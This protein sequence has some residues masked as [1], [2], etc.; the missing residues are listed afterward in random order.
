MSSPFL[1]WAALTAVRISTG[2]LRFVTFF[3]VGVSMGTSVI[4][5]SGGD[6][7]RARGCSVRPGPGRGP[8]GAGPRGRGPGSSVDETSTARDRSEEDPERVEDRFRGG[9]SRAGPRGRL[10]RYSPGRASRASARRVPGRVMTMNRH[11]SSTLRHSL[12]VSISR[13][14]SA[15][16]MKKMAR[17]GGAPGPCS[18]SRW[19]R[20]SRRPRS[21]A[22][23]RPG[24]GISGGRARPSPSGRAERRPPRIP[25]GAG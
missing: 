12:Q 17:P 25:C 19:N 16:T 8:E 10:L 7:A 23:S 1:D 4:R 15:P 6:R 22:G 2:R 13:N 20:T 21:R 18:A 14:A 3:G 9:A 11:P 24:A 5:V